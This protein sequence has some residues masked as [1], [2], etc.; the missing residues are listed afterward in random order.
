VTTEVE[1]PTHRLRPFWGRIMVLPSN[2]DDEARP[3]GLVV[4]LV[5][6]D[7][8][9]KRGIVAHVDRTRAEQSESI[10]DIEPGTVVYYVD[11]LRIQDC[12]MLLRHEIVA[13]EVGE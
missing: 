6:R 7:S 13:Y 9:V 2:L 12:V 11:G 1:T 3:S 4:P 5:Y 8:P 10:D